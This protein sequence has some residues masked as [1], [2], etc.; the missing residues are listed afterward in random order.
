M[1][2]NIRFDFYHL[3]AD[4][5][6]LRRKDNS[7]FFFGEITKQDIC[8]KLDKFYKTNSADF[9]DNGKIIKEFSHGKKWIKWVSIEKYQD[10]YKLL[11]TFND[12]EVDPRVLESVSNSVLTQK[13]PEKHGLRTLLHIVINTNPV[14]PNE[15]NLCVQS[16][17]GMS[18]KFLPSLFSE[19]LL[20]VYEDKFWIDADPMTQEEV[21]LKPHIEISSVT[22]SSIINAV[23]QGLLKGISLV[24]ES[25]ITSAF[26]QNNVM[27]N[28]I[29]TL[30]I[31]I[32]D[33]SSFLSN[34]TPTGLKNWLDSTKS[35]CRGEFSTDPKVYL[36]LKNQHNSGE[37]K[38]EF[39]DD[40][41]MGL[42]KRA[43]L[44]WEDR[45][46]NTINGLVS[47]KPLP[48]KQCFAI[49]LSNF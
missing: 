1:S 40:V 9:T 42:T 4:K 28:K 24:E 13:I 29:K 23:N 17:Q 30:N 11:F 6:R 16:V 2:V 21:N 37:T 31:S 3:R 26:D 45:D 5:S 48:I 38:Y 46:I 18:Y 43:Y 25:N 7:K 39:V 33:H 12:I 14:N 34:I 19:L 20:L 41:T 44:N 10:F 32:D 35:N 15:A 22:T 8:Q 49:M 27:K 36:M 47:E